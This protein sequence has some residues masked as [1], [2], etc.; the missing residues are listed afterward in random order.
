[1]FGRKPDVNRR[2]FLGG[3]GLAAFGAAVGG[4][5]PF[6]QNMPSGLIPAALA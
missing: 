1:L 2:G 4:A 6:S 5:I 3:A